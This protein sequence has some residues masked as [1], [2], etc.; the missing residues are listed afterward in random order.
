MD[1]S[2]EDEK[3][4]TFYPCD[5]EV[6]P[7]T[8]GTVSHEA[9]IT[10][11]IDTELLPVSSDQQQYFDSPD[12]QEATH[13]NVLLTKPVDDLSHTPIVDVLLDDSE[14]SAQPSVT[15]DMNDPKELTKHEHDLL[16]LHQVSQ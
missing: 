11:S 13:E 10:T 6:K 14:S 1:N 3:T 2:S 8:S 7:S 4:L 12:N 9:D 16:I 5:L 15:E